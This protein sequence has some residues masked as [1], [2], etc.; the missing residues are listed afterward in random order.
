MAWGSKVS[1]FVK[2]SLAG[3]RSFGFFFWD[4]A[5]CFSDRKPFS[6]RPAGSGQ[7]F[8]GPAKVLDRARARPGSDRAHPGSDLSGRNPVPRKSKAAKNGC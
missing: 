7:S 1:L 5:G 3:G 8:P 6:I 4:R 2:I